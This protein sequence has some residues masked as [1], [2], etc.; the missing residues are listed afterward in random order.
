M[1]RSEIIKKIEDVESSINSLSLEM[2][3]LK[4]ELERM[5]RDV[6]IPKNGEEYWHV[7]GNGDTGYSVWSDSSSDRERLAYGNCYISQEKA[8]LE[9]WKRAFESRMNRFNI[10][11]GG[12][13]IEWKSGKTNYSVAYNF[14]DDKIFVKNWNFSNPGIKIVFSD[15]KIAKKAMIENEN[16]FR[17]YYGVLKDD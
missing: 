3:S 5:D 10:E 16:E 4:K 11:N 14:P 13:P 1:N 6:F 15:R 8:E 9:S 2:Y 12:K 17:K 7:Y